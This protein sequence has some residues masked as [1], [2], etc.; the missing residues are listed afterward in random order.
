MFKPPSR[1][2]SLL[3]KGWNEIPELIGSGF[4]GLIGIAL[5]IFNLHYYYKNGLDNRKYKLEYTVIRDD[6][7]KAAFVRDPCEC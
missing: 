6:D 1:N 7:P 5:S 3:K 4:M 2:F